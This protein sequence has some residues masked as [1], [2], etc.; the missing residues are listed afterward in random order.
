MEKKD[1]AISINKILQEIKELK[2]IQDL[3][4]IET[5]LIT[6]WIATLI[7]GITLYVTVDEPWW[8]ITSIFIIIFTICPLC[9]FFASFFS[10]IG[11]RVNSLIGILF[12]ISLNLIAI[13]V[14]VAIIYLMTFDFILAFL[15]FLGIVNITPLFIFIIIEFWGIFIYFWDSRIEPN[16]NYRFNLLLPKKER[17]KPIIV[18]GKIIKKL[19]LP[20]VVLIITIFV[21]Y[22][23][24]IYEYFQSIIIFIIGFLDILF[25]I[26]KTKRIVKNKKGKIM[27]KSLI[28]KFSPIIVFILSMILGYLVFVFIN[29]WLS[30]YSILLQ[31][32]GVIF[33]SIWSI[34][35]AYP[36]VMKWVG[37]HF[38]KYTDGN[39]WRITEKKLIT[40]GLLL[41]ISGLLFELFLTF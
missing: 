38:P 20:I 33:L 4:S 31:I 14:T 22:S 24:I 26:Q 18:L 27:S 28:I 17:R 37:N 41:V 9:L 35:G 3:T 19:F 6:V 25:I 15:T 29:S 7:L 30:K 36:I 1:R 21:I 40:I 16:F 2:Q 5:I 12:T 8:K 39:I 34:I 23:I 13:A 10:T 11:M 32:F